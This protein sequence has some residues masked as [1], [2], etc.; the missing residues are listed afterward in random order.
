[1]LPVRPEIECEV[2]PVPSTV[3]ELVTVDWLS[4]MTEP[5]LPPDEVLDE[6]VLPSREMI[7]LDVPFEMTVWASTLVHR[8]NAAANV[9]R[10][11]M[12]DSPKPQGNRDT[13][14][15][16]GPGPS[17]APSQDIRRAEDFSSRPGPAC[18]PRYGARKSALSPAAAAPRTR[19]P[20]RP[21]RWR[22]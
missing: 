11:F 21:L 2:M 17:L 10:C 5:A 1:M 22:R 15:L 20:C 4:R 18:A 19:C 9:T 16:F 12:S 13:E 14:A 7:V 6:T 3:V 8:A